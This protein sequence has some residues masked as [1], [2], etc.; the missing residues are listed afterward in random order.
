V[1]RAFIAVE[2][3]P[4]TISRI[5]EAVDQLRPH[6]S[7]IRWVAPA[8]FHLTLKFLGNIDE[9]Q[10]E[11]IGATLSDALR[12][13]PRMTIN[14]KGLGVFPNPKR[15]RVLWV[16]LVGSQLTELATVVQSALVPLGFAREEKTFT[17][18]LTIGRWR[19]AERADR[20]LE[21][22]LKNWTQCDFGATS[23]NEIIVFQSDLK[24]AGAIYNRLKVVTLKH[25][26]VA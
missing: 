6:I 8:N 26:T 3:A 12:P 4:A 2:I 11:P 5:A 7:G 14:A 18:H 23:M 24:P 13:F 16:G 15:P 1:L 22:E 19:Q 21:H 20:A 10:I 17:P 9:S 25:D